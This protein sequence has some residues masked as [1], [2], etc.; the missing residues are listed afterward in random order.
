MSNLKENLER[1]ISQYKQQKKV[2]NNFEEFLSG[3]RKN[4]DNLIEQHEEISKEENSKSLSS[5]RDKASSY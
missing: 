5:K 4:I 3:K 2:S 1:K